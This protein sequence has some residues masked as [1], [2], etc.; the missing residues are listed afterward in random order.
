MLDF[1]PTNAAHL[2]GS[3][4]VSRNRPRTRSE[5]YGADGPSP[6]SV[7]AIVKGTVGLGSAIVQAR[8]NSPKGQAKQDVKSACGR[9]PL[10]PGKRG[11]WNQCVAEYAKQKTAS[12]APDTSAPKPTS[13]STNPKSADSYVK[14][15]AKDDKILGI[16]KT[17]VIVG[18]VILVLGGA[19]FVYFK[20]FKKGA[21]AP[22]AAPV[23]TV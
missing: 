15:T 23:A 22:V 14:H 8:R 2:D 1:E 18:S 5:Y 7:D 21:A 6:E 13:K 20:F 4:S 19:A 3:N 12:I 10:L 16:N 17:A 9:K 11:P